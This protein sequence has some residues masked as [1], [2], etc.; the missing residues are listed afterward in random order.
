M[1]ESL[2]DQSELA[3]M[4][5]IHSSNTVIVSLKLTRGMDACL[6]FTVLL[7]S[8]EGTDL[9]VGLPSVQEVLQIHKCRISKHRKRVDLDHTDL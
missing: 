1:W 2:T 6:D 4:S 3:A 8:C 7:L 9:S 5:V